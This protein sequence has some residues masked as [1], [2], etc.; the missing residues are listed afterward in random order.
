MIPKTLEVLTSELTSTKLRAKAYTCTVTARECLQTNVCQPSVKTYV[1][2]LSVKAWGHTEGSSVW[3]RTPHLPAELLSA[4]E[5]HI[6]FLTLLSMFLGLPGKM[7]LT[8]IFFRS[9]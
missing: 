1:Y 9:E 8:A 6:A 5:L 4:Y 3:S 7:K 2:R